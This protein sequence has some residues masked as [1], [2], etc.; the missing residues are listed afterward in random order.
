MKIENQTFGEFYK[1]PSQFS[2]VPNN[3]ILGLAFIAGARDG[4]T[5]PFYNMIDQHLIP[6]KVFSF[7]LSN[8]YRSGEGGEVTFGG[9]N[10]E[11]YLGEFHYLPLTELHQWQF[12]INKIMLGS[13][14]VCENGCQ[15]ICD[16][17]SSD[18]LG[19]VED[20]DKL[21]DM[22]G[23]T[24][25]GS[26]VLV[27]CDKV[28]DLPKITFNLNGKNFVLDGEDYIVRFGR[29]TCRVVVKGRRPQ[30]GRYQWILGDVF[31]RKFYSR[32]DFGN[33][34]IGFAPAIQDVVYVESN[35]ANN[36][37]S[38][39]PSGLPM[40]IPELPVKTPIN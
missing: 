28:S 17:G 20:I 21:Y 38:P 7:F 31:I 36:H 37:N 27:D 24:Y 8:N 19:P 35:S 23:V 32:F 3:G 18:L 22:I 14:E 6:E 25:S 16:T 26:E 9:S 30:P 11:R 12:K 39:I 1:A 29:D 40:A 33:Q 10:R 15:G 34:R 13:A 4:V 2:N 5:P